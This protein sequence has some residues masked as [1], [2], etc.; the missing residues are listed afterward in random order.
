[1]RALLLINDFPYLSG[2]LQ[3][4]PEGVVGARLN[5]LLEGILSCRFSAHPTAR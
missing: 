1:M 3:R 2:Y 5:A 4:F